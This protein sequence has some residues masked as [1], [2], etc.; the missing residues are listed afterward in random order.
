MANATVCVVSSLGPA[1]I[2][3][4]QPVMGA[5]PLSSLTA[6]SPMSLNC[7]GSLTEV[8]AIV[9]MWLV[10]VSLPPLVVPPSSSAVTV[11]V[12]VPFALAAGVNVRVPAGSMVGWVWKRLVWSTWT[13]KAR[14][15][16]GFVGW[17]GL[18]RGRPSADRNGAAVF[19][20]VEVAVVVEG[21]RVVD[22]RDRDRGGV[23]GRSVV[24]AVA[25]ATVI[26]GS[27]CDGCG[28]VG[29]GGRC[30]GQG[31]VGADRGKRGEQGRLVD[32]DREADV[33]CGFV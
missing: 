31:S 27:D 26:D 21:R 11:M 22:G 25:G 17:S 32:G 14:C 28:A 18:D 2:E 1:T 23:N 24:A 4:A 9:A 6:M 29:V 10:D 19:V 20:H 3:W 8:M 15:L 16:V 30:E 13:V 33:L 5:G 7:G 12:A